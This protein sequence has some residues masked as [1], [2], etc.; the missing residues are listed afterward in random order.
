MRKRSRLLVACLTISVVLNGY[1]QS[2]LRDDF[3][4]L[5]GNAE[6]DNVRELSIRSTE[7]TNYLIRVWWNDLTQMPGEH[8]IIVDC[9]YKGD[10]LFTERLWSG[11]RVMVT[12]VAKRAKKNHDE[13]LFLCALGWNDSGVATNTVNSKGLHG[14]P[15]E[16]LRSASSDQGRF[17]ALRSGLSQAQLATVQC[18]AVSAAFAIRNGG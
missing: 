14:Y 5:T 10:I 18:S 15:W 13:L 11:N 8:R 4:R 12:N 3:R 2:T 6:Y 16:G 9:L 1:A 17:T 7:G